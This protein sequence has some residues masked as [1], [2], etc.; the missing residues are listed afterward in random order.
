MSGCAAAARVGGSL[1]PFGCTRFEPTNLLCNPRRVGALVLVN[2][3]IDNRVE[4][5]DR[6]FQYGDG[7]FTTLPICSGRAAFLD[8]HLA[9]LANDC[10]RLGIPFRCASE[11]A[12]E[13]NQLCRHNPNGVLKIQITRGPGGRGYRPPGQPQ[14]TRVLS[15]HKGSDYDPSLW[16]QGVTVRMCSNRLGCNSAL[17]GIKHMNRLE[18]ILA[19]AEWHVETVH[20]GLMLDQEGFLIEGTMSNVFLAR[21]G[22]LVTPKLDRCGV[23][24]IMRSLV[25]ETARQEGIAVEERPIPPAELVH[26]EEVFLT[27]SNIRVWPVSRLESVPLP[28]GPLTRRL[29]D[30]IDT[31]FGSEEVDL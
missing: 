1:I 12:A 8:R 3:Q 19:R 31:R 20:E 24:G 13:A 21:G 14:P 11:V 30:L 15:V 4:W 18:Q 22:R 2:G 27:N 9:R 29:L 28:I 5:C 25:I 17:A 6:G 7:V 23:A 26:A 10:G 16:L